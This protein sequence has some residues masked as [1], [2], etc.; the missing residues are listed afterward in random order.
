MNKEQARRNRVQWRG[1]LKR[2]ESSQ[3]SAVDFARKEGVSTA[4]LY[5]WRKRLTGN[6]SGGGPTERLN[7]VEIPLP[8][9]PDHPRCQASAESRFVVTLRTGDSIQVPSDFEPL[10]LQKLVHVLEDRH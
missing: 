10:S 6:G 1:R 7:F 2:W 9:G 8:P 3:L 5:Q 4:S